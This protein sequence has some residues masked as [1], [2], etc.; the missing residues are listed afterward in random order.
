MAYFRVLLEGKGIDIEIGSAK[1][2]G[3]YASRLVRANSEDAAAVKAKHMLLVQWRQLHGSES[4]PI[5]AVEE[6]GRISF[7]HGVLARQP[8]HSFY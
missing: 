2:I 7:W 6:I 1:A 3:F 8:G 5:L 4:D